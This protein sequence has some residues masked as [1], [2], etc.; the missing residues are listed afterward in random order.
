MSNNKV[1]KI[2][3]EEFDQRMGLAVIQYLCEQVG[4]DK[5]KEITDDEIEAIDGNA[6]MT[7][8]FCQAMVRCARRIAV[9]C[10]FVNDIVP[11]IINEWGHVA[12]RVTKKRVV[13]ILVSY[14]DNDLNSADPDYVRE[15]LRDVCGCTLD[16]L[17]DLGI[18]DW[19]GFEED[20]D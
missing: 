11:Y 15:T 14:I 13:D 2:I 19:L 3:N 5:A 16:E 9:E 7:K 4:I 1:Y 10:S 12:G 6:L 17:R 20:E 18:A 8:S